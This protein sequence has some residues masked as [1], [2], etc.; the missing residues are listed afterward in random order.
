MTNMR[1][2]ADSK[3]TVNPTS[4]ALGAGVGGLLGLGV[5]RYLLGNKSAKSNIL[6]GLAGAGIGG[7]IGLLG[8]LSADNLTLKEA[9]SIRNKYG[10]AVLRHLSPEM[11][12]KVNQVTSGIGPADYVQYGV[13]AGAGSLL[14]RATGMATARLQEKRKG[15]HTPDG[16]IVVKV[17]GKDKTFNVAKPSQA[18]T[19]LGAVGNGVTRLWKWTTGEAPTIVTPGLDRADLKALWERAQKD[20]IR[21]SF[22]PDQKQVLREI[23]AKDPKLAKS[24]ADAEKKVSAMNMR[25]RY[26][27]RGGWIGA[28]PAI[29]HTL[30]DYYQYFTNK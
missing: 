23:A 19:S 26:A 15:I 7:G 27:N 11:A 5:N 13:E 30:Y 14:G 9:I 17:N 3:I 2:F 18:K 12:D 8:G 24:L 1:K 6:A 22:T 21:I 16:Q 28:L 4:T 10:N 20:K 25:K 29:G